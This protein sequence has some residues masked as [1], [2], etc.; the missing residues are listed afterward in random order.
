MEPVTINQMQEL[1]SI[2]NKMKVMAS[3]HEWEELSR[4]DGERRAVLK[5]DSRQKT[6]LSEEFVGDDIG[7]EKAGDAVIRAELK[8]KILN[9]DNEIVTCLQA[10]RDKLLSE[11]RGLSAQVKAKSIYAQTNSMN[12]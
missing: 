1:L 5:Y 9:L 7:M 10:D 3:E 12:F 8:K 11:N 6:Q 2:M 4:L